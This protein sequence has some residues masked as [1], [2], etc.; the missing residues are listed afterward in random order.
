MIW[1]NCQASLSHLAFTNEHCGQFFHIPS[2]AEIRY[3]CAYGLYLPIQCQYRVRLRSGLTP[4]IWWRAAPSCQPRSNRA[5]YTRLKGN[6]CAQQEYALCTPDIFYV[7][8]FLPTR[9]RHSLPFRTDSL[10]DNPSYLHSRTEPIQV[11]ALSKS[12]HWWYRDSHPVIPWVIHSNH[13]CKFEQ[14]ILQKMDTFTMYK[15]AIFAICT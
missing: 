1:R 12:A 4:T 5:C 8:D 6:I 13:L 15:H 14:A 2:S 7:S 10:T 9:T 11:L 3:M